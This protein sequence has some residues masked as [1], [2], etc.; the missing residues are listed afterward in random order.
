M[1]RMEFAESDEDIARCYPVMA[2]LRPQVGAAEFLERVRRQG[3]G[4]YRLVYLEVDG[5]VRAVAGFRVL[6]CLA[7]GRVLY[8]DDLV[9]QT[10]ERSRGYGRMLLARVK[11]IA[12]AEVCGE[13]HLDSAMH[14]LDAH[15]F[16]DR[17][18]LDRVGY[19]FSVAT[20]HTA[21]E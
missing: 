11:R 15:R 3:R 21:A 17:E 6:E 12:R 4:G 13:L 5:A 8:L 10:S 18:G 20:D 2:E 14:R 9:T 19:H 16:Y 1:V 7:W